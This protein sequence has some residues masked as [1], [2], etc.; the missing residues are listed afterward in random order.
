MLRDGWSTWKGLYY[1]TVRLPSKK[2]NS[3]N[4]NFNYEEQARISYTIFIHTGSSVGIRWRVQEGGGLDSLTHKTLASGLGS[5]QETLMDI[6]DGVIWDSQ[7]SQEFLSILID[8]S[9]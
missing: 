7:T 2:S 4:K 3:I 8:L 1:R 9:F 5:S 6:F